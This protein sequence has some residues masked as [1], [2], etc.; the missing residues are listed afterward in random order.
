MHV[1]KVS[2]NINVHFYFRYETI[3][4]WYASQGIFHHIIF[5]ILCVIS[6]SLWA[7]IPLGAILNDEEK[8]LPLDGWYP[9]DTTNSFNFNLVWLQQVGL[10]PFCCFDVTRK[11]SIFRC[12]YLRVLKNATCKSRKLINCGR[13]LTRRLHGYSFPTENSK[14][15]NHIILNLVHNFLI[16]D[17]SSCSINYFTFN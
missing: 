16:N 8:K 7:C 15:G 2:Y 13:I 12:L 9:F 11:L 5:Q 6:I 17:F 14:T 3:V 1:L 10:V 4:S